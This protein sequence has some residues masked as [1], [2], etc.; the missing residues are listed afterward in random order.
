MSDMTRNTTGQCMCGAVKFTARDV[1]T[2]FTACN[3]DMCRRWTG[4]RF[5]GAHMPRENITI[6]GEDAITT[7]QS[8]QW[9]QRNF[10]TK[11]GSALWYN[12]VAGPEAG[13]ISLSVGL[14]NNA[15]GMTLAQEYFVDFKTSI[16]ALPEDR[17]QMTEAEVLAMFAPNPTQKESQDDQGKAN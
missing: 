8:S 6:T 2:E 15:D 3:C 5:L 12:F 10:C 11:C 4:S 14:L 7:I 17:I 9:A 1:P 13:G 16:H